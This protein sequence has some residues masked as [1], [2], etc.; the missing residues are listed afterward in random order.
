MLGVQGKKGRADDEVRHDNLLAYAA[1]DCEVADRLLAGFGFR[2]QELQAT[3]RGNCCTFQEPRMCWRCWE[4]YT[5]E[6]S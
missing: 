2:F 1:R 3:T 6:S 5:L 4:G